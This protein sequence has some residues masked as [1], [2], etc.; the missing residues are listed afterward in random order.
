[1]R[2]ERRDRFEEIAPLLDRVEKPTRYLDHEWG[3]CRELG[4]PFH[5]C[6]VYP[7]T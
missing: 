5:V 1:M 4:G 2:L 3:S 7:D 6:L